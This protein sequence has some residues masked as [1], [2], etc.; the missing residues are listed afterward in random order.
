MRN[1]NST[2]DLHFAL[3]IWMHLKNINEEKNY[4]RLNFSGNI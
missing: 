4:E 1:N 2:F 3:G